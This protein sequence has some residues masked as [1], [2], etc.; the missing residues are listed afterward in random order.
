MIYKADYYNETQIESFIF[1]YGFKDGLSQSKDVKIQNL[2][3]QHYKNNK[4]IISFNPLDYGKVLNITKLVNETLYILIDDKNFIIKILH[5]ENK[6]NI[7]ISKD[8]DT[9]IKFIDNKLS[10]NRFVRILENKKFYFENN[11]EILYVKEMKTKFIS[12][13]KPIKIFNNKFIT[14][15]IETY[16]KDSVLKVFCISIYD[17]INKK[18]FVITDYNNSEDFI[19]A[20]LKSIL[21]RKYNSYNIYIHNMGN[22]DMIFLMKYL[23]KLGS[24]NPIIHNNRII[25]INFNY[26]KNNEYQ[27]NFRDSYLLLPKSLAELTEGFHVETLKSVFPYLFVNENNLN[28]IGEVPDFKYFDQKINKKQ[29]NIYKSNFKNN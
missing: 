17:G 9:I 8:G 11:K 20:G 13:L 28:Y 1:S 19:L 6:N 21:L 22:F 5:N 12:K 7:E 26:G 25:S 23:V 3:F 27:I 15:D 4:L 16:I 2:N 24:I 10:D 14:F 18:S 29:Y